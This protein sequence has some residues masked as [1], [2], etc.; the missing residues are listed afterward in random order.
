MD[1]I[2]DLKLAIIQIDHPFLLK[3]NLKSKGLNK[4]QLD[5]IFVDKLALVLCYFFWVST[6]KKWKLNSSSL[7][8]FFLL[9]YNT[10]DY[11]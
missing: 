2:I 10:T 1:E 6:D 11:F 8:A 3:K 4:W 5:S 9:V 7:L